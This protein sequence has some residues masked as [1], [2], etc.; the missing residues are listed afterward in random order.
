MTVFP[1]EIEMK[2]WTANIRF[3]TVIIKEERDRDEVFETLEFCDGAISSP[4][5][6][7]SRLL[8][9]L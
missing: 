4:E 8:G 9:L 7:E 6:R 1:R 5:N 3:L 2:T